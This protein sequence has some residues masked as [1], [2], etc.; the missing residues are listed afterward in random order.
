MNRIAGDMSYWIYP[1]PPDGPMTTTCKWPAG[2]V[3][4]AVVEVDGWR[5]DGPG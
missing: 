5:S 2:G 3:P 1:L 4:D